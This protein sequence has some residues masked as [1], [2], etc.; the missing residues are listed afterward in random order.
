M[1]YWN[2]YK[3]RLKRRRRR[4]RSVR[5]SKE[6]SLVYDNTDKILKNDILLF[7][8]IR[9]E[10]TRLKFFLKYYRNMGVNH[11]FFV[12]NGSDDGSFEYLREQND[13]S[14]WYTENSYKRSKFGVDW[15]NGLQSKYGC[16]KWCLVV[17]V[18]E[19]FIYPH[20]DKRSL[21]ALTSWLD[22]SSIKSFGTLLLDTYP[23]RKITKVYYKSGDNPFDISPYFDAGN[24]YYKRNPEY[25][26]L[27]IQ[28]GPRQRVF[29]ANNPAYAPAL[30]KIP[31][32]KWSRGNVYVSSTHNL[33]PRSLNLV[34]DE[35]GGQRACGCLMHMKYLDMFDRKAK[36]EIKR[37]Q[38]YAGSREYKLYLKN[39]KTLW[40]PQS[41]K[42]I[43]WEQLEELGLMSM[44][45]WG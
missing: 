10:Y 19:F 37:K 17:D 44:G 12:D 29:F 38:H 33:L 43:N 27:W 23:K 15:L 18:D 11:F 42:F 14:V 40:T 8:T 25:G 36:E 28:G 13:V 45:D 2:R 34:Y 32:V 26:N 16:K 39:N 31:L 21:R 3:L 35:N 5:K 20:C 9:N 24:Y 41:T 30:N 4:I 7:S 22:S 6:L 1:K